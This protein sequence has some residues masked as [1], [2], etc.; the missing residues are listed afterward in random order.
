MRQY[1]II[2]LIAAFSMGFPTLFNEEQVAIAQDLPEPTTAIE[3]ADDLIT[4]RLV[5]QAQDAVEYQ[6]VGDT[7]LRTIL[8]DSEVTLRSLRVPVSLTFHYR[9]IPRSFSEQTGLLEVELTQD[10]ATG[11]LDI[12]MMPT[13]D[14]ALDSSTIEIDVNGDVY[15][16]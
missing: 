3:L 1:T 4:V 2:G 7:E 16:F 14:P 9:S 11:D 12:I 15:V 8:G 6:I 5:N 10:P 13:Q